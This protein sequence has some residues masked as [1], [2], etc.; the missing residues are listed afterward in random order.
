VYETIERFAENGKVRPDMNLGIQENQHCADR[1][2]S[3]MNLCI[4][5]IVGRG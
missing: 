4:G 1:I 2:K 5:G 3:G